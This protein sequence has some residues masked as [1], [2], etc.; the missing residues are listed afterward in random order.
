MVRYLIPLLLT[1]FIVGCQNPITLIDKYESFNKEIYINTTE[2]KTNFDGTI[3]G[4]HGGVLLKL[5]KNWV[6]NDIK[7]NGFEGLLRIDLISIY[8]TELLLDDGI[9]V[10]MELEIDFIITKKTIVKKTLIKFKG[11]EFG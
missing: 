10:E 4:N 11:K 6:D 8:T 3:E 2:K 1:F 5:L 7:T 9:R